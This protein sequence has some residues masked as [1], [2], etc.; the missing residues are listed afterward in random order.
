MPHTIGQRQRQDKKRRMIFGVGVV[1]AYLALQFITQTF[2]GHAR[3]AVLLQLVNWAIQL[4]FIAYALNWNYAVMKQRQASPFI[5]LTSSM[6]ES[7]LIGVICTYVYGHVVDHWPAL[8]LRPGLLP[9]PTPLSRALSIGVMTGLMHGG[10]WVMA[11]VFPF[12]AE[13]A[14]FN[15]LESD[16]LRAAAELSQ[17]R[18][19]LEPHFM[20]NTLNAI[21]GLVTEDPKKSRR[22]LAALGDLLREAVREDQTEYTVHEEIG[23]LTRYAELLEARHE[24][25]LSFEWRVDEFVRYALIPRLVLQPL[26][27][28]AVKH[29]ALKRDRGG[30][31]V[32]AVERVE[33]GGQSWLRCTVTDN[34]PGLGELRKD[35]K[36]LALVRAQLQLR[37]P[38]GELR[39]QSL[40]TGTQA[41]VEVPLELSEQLEAAQ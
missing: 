24:D 4:G 22:L 7:V 37:E 34:G 8:R 16:R 10:F 41:I 33:D 5:T 32:I 38:A 35:S 19:H 28:N 25:T 2:S 3:S 23:W 36:G 6:L 27:E 13:D 17:L 12:A 15:R 31:V 40:E 39:L 11:S 21:A 26:V 20:L 29:G 14:R 18:A 1:L 30:R 9:A